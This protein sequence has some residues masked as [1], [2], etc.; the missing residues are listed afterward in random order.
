M[1]SKKK[2]DED[3]VPETWQVNTPHWV[4][5]I[6]SPWVKRVFKKEVPGHGNQIVSGPRFNAHT[7]KY[8]K[9]RGFEVGFKMGTLSQLG[10]G[11]FVSSTPLNQNNEEV[12]FKSI[13]KNVKR[14]AV[15]VPVE[16]LTKKH[17]RDTEGLQLI[18]IAR[19][20]GFLQIGEDIL[21]A[22]NANRPQRF[23]WTCKGLELPS[24]N[25]WADTDNSIC[26]SGALNRWE[27]KKD[28]L[29]KTTP[30]P[31]NKL[32]SNIALSAILEEKA[33]SE[34]TSEG[35]YRLF[36][37]NEAHEVAAGFKGLVKLLTDIN[38]CPNRNHIELQTKS[39]QLRK[40][41]EKAITH[42]T[43]IK[44]GSRYVCTTCGT[45]TKT[46]YTLHDRGG[47]SM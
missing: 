30:N 33:K 15:L 16:S 26:D 35:L 38:Q 4:T 8:W 32:P 19:P 6:I 23:V 41:I 44:K 31:K 5:A 2:K 43:S 12:L 13:L 25:M 10:A 3:V 36:E 14:F 42:S 34:S 24:V 47:K 22:Q 40:L 7:L 17:I 9:S 21:A 45:W 11:T 37:S 46:Y 28:R 29:S 39:I 1:R 18:H 20:I 27:Y